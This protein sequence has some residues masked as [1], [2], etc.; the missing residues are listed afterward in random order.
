MNHEAKEGRKHGLQYR[1]IEEGKEKEERER[2]KEIFQIFSL[3]LTATAI[4]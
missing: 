2:V 3:T 1:G 4:L